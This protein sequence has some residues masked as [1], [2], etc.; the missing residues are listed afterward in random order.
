M[1]VLP[2]FHD[3]SGSFPPPREC[4][5]R[6]LQLLREGI[7]N[8]KR[9]QVLVM[10][11]GGGKTMTALHLINE[12]RK[13]ERRAIFLCDRI[14]LIE[15]TSA[16]ADEYGI[17]HGI[18]QGGH[19]RRDPDQLFQIGSIQTIGMRKYGTP[20]D[21]IIV[22]ECHSTYAAWTE[23]A[24]RTDA[25][26]IGLTATPFTKGLGNHFDAVV[27]A[28]TMDE[29]TR[30]GVLVP[31]RILTCVT[32][33]MA[34]AAT[35]GGEW[36]AKAAGEREMQIVGDVVAEWRTH[37]EG[38]KTI[39]FGADIA[40][41]TQLVQRFNEAGI[42]AAAYT[43]ETPDAERAE[44]LKEFSKPD[45]GIRILVSVAALAKGFDQPD[46]GCVI[47]ARPLRK[48]LSEVIQM[49]GRGLR[50]AL[51]KSDCILLDFSGNARRFHDD[52]V[53]VYFN[54]CGDLDT[55]QKLDA[56]PRDEPQDFEPSGCPQCSHKP[57]RQ[58]CLSCGYEKPTKC[59]E[60]EAQG[61]MQEIRIGNKK[62][63]DSPDDLW[64]QVCGHAR[65]HSRPEKQAGRAANLYRNITGKWPPR[66]F[67]FYSTEPAPVSAATRNKIKSLDI[68]YRAAMKKARAA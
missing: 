7:R 5:T 47:D 66:E 6:A 31:M 28:A 35:S 34:G 18:I 49:W 14:A 32:P 40:Y 33:D 10:P 36:T 62:L 54:G 61:V 64:R 44:L 11:T 57:F 55:A 48:S 52:F 3:V 60:S 16:R 38:R 25:V 26:V 21:I 50:S 39:A 53:D 41:C 4:Q 9:R 20:T 13:K 63:A 42:M 23:W 29:L 43:S 24:A 30:Q 27:N 51:G 67:D 56:K 8:G 12:A 22:D 1:N 19:W 59:L 58:R 15:Q 2:L 37:G 45:S 68:A 17:P 46:V 65:A